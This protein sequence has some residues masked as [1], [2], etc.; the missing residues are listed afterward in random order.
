M[1]AQALTPKDREFLEGLILKSHSTLHSDMTLQLNDLRK[2]VGDLRTDV[3][4]NKDATVGLEKRVAIQNGR[5]S[6]LES[7]WEKLAIGIIVFL[8]TTVVSLVAFIFSRFI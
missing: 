8:L 1:D 2:G 7:R 4:E 3:K 5:V 6:K